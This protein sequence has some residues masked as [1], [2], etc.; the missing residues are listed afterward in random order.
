MISRKLHIIGGGLAGL[1]LG[2]GLRKAGVP[3]VVHEAGNYP[4]H[5]VCGEFI[6]GVTDA[7]LSRL[8][9]LD[10]FEGALAPRSL[11][12]MNQRDFIH[13]GCLPEPARAISRYRLDERLANRFQD[14]GGE[15]QADQRIAVGNGEGWIRASGRAY[16]AG[17]TRIGLKAHVRGPALHADLDMH[18][19]GNGY[20]GLVEIEDGWINAC[21]I[22]RA[23]RSIR[24]RGME[25]LGAYLRA[26]GHHALATSL[27]AAE[28]RESSFCAVAGFDPGPQSPR[29]AEL[30]IGDVERMIPPFTGNG[31]SMAFEAA[32]T[33]LDPIVAWST[34][35]ASW[36]AARNVVRRRLA[37]RFR[38]R[39]I[40]SGIIEPRLGHPATHDVMRLLLSSRWLP[41]P[42]AYSLFR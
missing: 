13:R 21:G 14:L 39:M 34:G 35:E 16:K 18:L 19:A 38:K 26:G 8:G 42:F 25:L 9:I 17:G 20:I 36:E 1:S 5:R 22:F 30:G 40:A 27:L 11:C 41:F 32:A 6:S 2:I 28:V 31:M 15:L 4:R 10:A 29:A 12:W 7:V 23:D 24:G 33:A 37:A 3:V